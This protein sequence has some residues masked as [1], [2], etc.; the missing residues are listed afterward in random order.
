[1]P[2]EKLEVKSPNLLT[3]EQAPSF[4][5]EKI[6]GSESSSVAE[7]APTPEKDAGVVEPPSNVIPFPKREV[8]AAP[9]VERDPTVAAIDEILEKDL[10][11]I[12]DDMNANDRTKFIAAGEE[13]TAYIAK[14]LGV[15]HPHYGRTLDAITKWL[16][17]IPMVNKEFL[18]Q[19]A[20]CKND[21]IM[22]FG[23][24]QEQKNALAA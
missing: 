15:K 5:T 3:P 13:L 8:A 22:E 17:K 11:K 24:R 14:E 4:E 21:Q 16:H 19:A 6:E 20:K 23:E 9:K 10:G 7:V 1:M 18:R 12:V 2:D